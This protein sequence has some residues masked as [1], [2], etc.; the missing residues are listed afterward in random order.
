MWAS[1]IGHFH[2][3]AV[4]SVGFRKSIF[5]ILLLFIHLW[6]RG[7]IQENGSQTNHTKHSNFMWFPPLCQM[8]HGVAS[9][10]YCIDGLWRLKMLS[11]RFL[12]GFICPLMWYYATVLYFG[13]YYRKDP[14]E[15]AG[16]AAS[17]IAVKSLSL[18]LSLSDTH[19]STQTHK[20]ELSLNS[21]RFL[22]RGFHWHGL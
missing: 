14:R 12:L 1:M 18:S 15:R 3:L 20:K 22:I 16:L 8:Q 11:F 5:I 6:G 7:L 10:F 21:V 2:V 9:F 4:G 13:N 19:P 17:A